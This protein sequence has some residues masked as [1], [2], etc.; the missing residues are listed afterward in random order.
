MIAPWKSLWH[1][2][3]F[4]FQPFEGR[5]HEHDTIHPFFKKF[6]FS[7]WLLCSC[8]I[9]VQLYCW[10][11]L[12]VGL[13]AFTSPCVESVLSDAN[14]LAHDASWQ[15]S[16]MM[17]SHR[18]GKAK[19]QSC[20]SLWNQDSRSCLYNGRIAPWEARMSLMK[21]NRKVSSGLK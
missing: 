15:F 11:I 7:F 3:E 5:P 18:V 17:L 16:L 4:Q 20:E 2:E 6:F 8:N 10:T 1:P 19:S 13:L 14:I 21:H 9:Y 12:F